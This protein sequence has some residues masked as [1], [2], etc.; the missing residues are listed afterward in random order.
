MARD[1]QVVLEPMSPPSY[2]T[3]QKERLNMNSVP[4]IRREKIFIP[5]E[6]TSSEVKEKY[7][8]SA[9]SA[10]AAMNQG[11]FIKN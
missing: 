9:K 3:F 6:M 1:P 8:L 11:F 7:G 5:P 10:R 4:E 2:I